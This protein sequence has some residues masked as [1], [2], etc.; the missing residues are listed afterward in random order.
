MEREDARKL[1]PDAQ[2]ERRRQVVRA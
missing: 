2:H 1:S